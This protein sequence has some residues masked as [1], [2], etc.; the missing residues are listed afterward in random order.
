MEI[1]CSTESLT[2]VRLQMPNAAL[3]PEL[4]N[5]IKKMFANATH[6]QKI[7]LMGPFH[8]FVAIAQAFRENQNIREV[9]VMS[10]TSMPEAQERE[11][12]QILHSMS[13]LERLSLQAN[14][15][16]SSWERFAET[17]NQANSIKSLK[18]GSSYIHMPPNALKSLAERLKEK[19][20]LECLY[21]SKIFLLQS[22]PIQDIVDLYADLILSSSKLQELSLHL[23]GEKEAMEQF[24]NLLL[25]RISQ[26]PT[27]LHLKLKLDYLF[28]RS[29]AAG[30]LKLSLPGIEEL[31][32]ANRTLLSF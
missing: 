12:I 22:Y 6:I 32:R 17:F 3:P 14:L 31:F 9:E 21:L 5:A 16:P 13:S 26:S 27:L 8:D 4:M 23:D 19:K 11:L 30:P 2:E 20:D 15:Q 29:T 18:I 25:P 10:Y 28:R 7:Q 1:I 24:L